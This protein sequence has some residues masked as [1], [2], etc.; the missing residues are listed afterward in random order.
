MLKGQ[1]LR[2]GLFSFF[3]TAKTDFFMKQQYKNN[4]INFI[5]LLVFEDEL[6]L[7]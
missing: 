6:F 1:R 2:S 5:L 4:S 3:N 7:D